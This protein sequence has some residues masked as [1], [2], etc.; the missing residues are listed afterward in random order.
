MLLAGQ[1]QRIRKLT[2]SAPTAP[3]LPASAP[4]GARGSR[5]RMISYLAR[6]SLPRFVG[7]ILLDVVQICPINTDAM[8]S[9]GCTRR[10]AEPG[11][12]ATKAA[13]RKI[14]VGKMGRS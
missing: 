1:L 8:Q 10:Q 14:M 12:T 3:A 5:E 4:R 11:F 7:Y 9:K 2:D 6:Q 13:E